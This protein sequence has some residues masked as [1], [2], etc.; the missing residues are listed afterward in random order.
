M[1]ELE[2]KKGKYCKL[3]GRKLDIE[4]NYTTNEKIYTDTCIKC[5]SKNTSNIPSSWKN[6]QK[7][8]QYQTDEYEEF[9]H[10]RSSRLIDWKDYRIK[11]TIAL[12][13]NCYYNIFAAQWAFSIIQ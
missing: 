13:S 4:I 7:K 10:R 8:P 3:C 2:R 12:N 5:L 6:Y 1:F 9:M 11:K